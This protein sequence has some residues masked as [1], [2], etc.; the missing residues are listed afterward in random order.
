[1]DMKIES[2]K[3][4]FAASIGLLA[5][6]AG[7][8]YK[9]I[10]VLLLLMSVDTFIGWIKGIKLKEWK[11][12]KARWGAVGKIAELLLIACLYALDWVFSLDLLKY[13]G[14]YYFGI[15]ELASVFENFA[16]MGGNVP[17]GI[18]DLLKELQYSIGTDS[19]KKI[20]KLIDNISGDDKDDN[21]Q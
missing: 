14:I 1:M 21:K 3:A 17:K 18:V 20:K 5:L 2:L 16:E 19:V 13:I 10:L 9:H 15:C 6:I 4:V 8:S 12:C 7:D 11:S